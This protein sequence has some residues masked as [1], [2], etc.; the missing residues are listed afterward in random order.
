MVGAVLTQNTAWDNVEKAIAN[1]KR[2]ACLDPDKIAA[3]PTADLAES[4]RPSGYFNVKAKRLRHLC[5]WYVEQGKHPRLSRWETPALRDALL[6]VHGIGPETAD[7]ILLYAFERPVFV[8]DAYTR[9]I[10]SRLDIFPEDLPY[11][12]L[13]AG[14]E[15]AL[16]TDRALFNE[17]HALIVR[18]GKDIC[19]KRP[20]CDLCC[21]GRICI[22]PRPSTA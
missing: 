22:N 8:I 11:E 12:V 3:L 10:F 20:R 18:H 9:R 15:E 4:I 6:S 2:A 5:A 13:R 17:Y 7:D 19:R 14:C 21:L 1:L 16:P